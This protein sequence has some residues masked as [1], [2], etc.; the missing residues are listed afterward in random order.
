MSATPRRGLPAASADRRF[1]RAEVRPGR[2]RR[3]LQRAW[4]VGR[5][6]LV[7]GALAGL[8][9]VASSQIVGARILTVDSVIVRGNHRLTHGEVESLISHVRGENL[10]LVDLDRVRA[11]LLDSP[12]VAG[13][14]AR[15]VFPSTLDIAIAERE[16]VAIARLSQQ[17]YLVDETGI[18]IDEYGPQHREFDLPIVDGLAAPRTPDGPVIDPARVRL[19]AR[20]LR[21]LQAQPAL[22]RA[23]SQVNV[24]DVDNVVVLLG[25]D[26]TYLHLGDA[27]FAERLQRYLEMTPLLADRGR[28]VESVDLRFGNRLVLRDRR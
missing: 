2:R 24:A 4:H 25:D 6:V 10:L 1:R 3:V 19:A 16:P 7:V 18:I 28:E 27:Q 26:P 13:V 12:W 5:A 23:L 8:G 22:Y 11:R 15:R 17:L 21:S 14:A 9:A 20:F